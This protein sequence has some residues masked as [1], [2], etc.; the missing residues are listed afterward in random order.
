[1]ATS[2]VTET[3]PSTAETLSL[4]INDEPKYTKYPWK[5]YLAHTTLTKEA[6]YEQYDHVDPA[7][8]AD[9][10][11]KALFAAIKE[12]KDMTPSTGTEVKGVQLSALTD[13]Q[14]DE[15]SLWAAERGLLVFRDQDFVHQ[16]PEFLKQYG[17]HFGRLHVHSF[18]SHMKGHPEILANLRDSNKTVFDHYSAG[19]LTTT[20]WHSD[21]TYEK[22]PMGTTFLAVLENPETGGDTLYLNSMEAYDKLSEPMKA[23]LEGLD[24]LHSGQRQAVHGSKVSVY[25]REL[26]DTVHPIVRKHPVTGRKALWFPPEYISGIVGLKDE[27]SDAITRMLYSHLQTGLEFHTRAKWEP[28]T[29]VVYDNRMVMH[30]VVLDYPLGPNEKR[31]HIR[32]TPQAER[33][34]PARSS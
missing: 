25:R 32:I 2:T 18:G 31:H 1:M 22:N 14:K 21:M 28:G 13:Q 34:I 4:P 15:L 9:P 30:S 23:F 29:V 24:A 6:P 8:R 27:E 10:E 26:V 17:S 7:S 16:S 3:V 19:M 5:H 12:K 33:P 20:R 11:K